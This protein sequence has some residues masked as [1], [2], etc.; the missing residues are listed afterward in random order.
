MNELRDELIEALESAKKKVLNRFELYQEKF[1]E[2][3]SDEEMK[4]FQDEIFDSQYCSIFQIERFE[5]VF[6]FKLG[7]LF[8]TQFDDEIL[9][10]VVWYFFLCQQNKII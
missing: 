10:N 7:I 9:K 8:F 2:I 6:D 3:K 1:L 5:T 4:K